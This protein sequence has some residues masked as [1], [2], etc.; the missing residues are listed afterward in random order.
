MKIKSETHLTVPALS[1]LE[2]SE[3]MHFDAGKIYIIPDEL[4]V[5]LIEL[6]PTGILSQVEEPE[7]E[8][9]TKKTISKKEN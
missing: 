3:P 6:C 7:P 8:V 1:L 4:A 2:N 9:R 5:K